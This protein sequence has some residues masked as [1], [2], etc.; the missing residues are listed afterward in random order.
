MGDQIS[1]YKTVEAMCTRGVEGTIGKAA[2]SI[3]RR[4]RRVRK[5][6]SD[7]ERKGSKVGRILEEDR[8]GIDMETNSGVELLDLG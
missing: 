5:V 8:V 6:G 3:D 4:Y 1:K 7:D 2:R